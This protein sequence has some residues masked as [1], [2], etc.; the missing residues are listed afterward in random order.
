VV[1]AG[2][3]A[4]RVRTIADI[5]SQYGFRQASLVAAATAREPTI[6]ALWRSLRTDPA[7]TPHIGAHQATPGEGI[8]INV[9]QTCQIA[10]PPRRNL[11]PEVSVTITSNRPGVAAQVT[12]GANLNS[13]DGSY[14]GPTTTVGQGQF[15][16]T[17]SEVRTGFVILP[18]GWPVLGVGAEAIWADGS[19][20][21]VTL[22]Y[23]QIACD[24]WVW[25]SWLMP[26][27][28]VL[29]RL[30]SPSTGSISSR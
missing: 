13:P 5:S 30:F 3:S 9:A 28:A 24:P 6:A 15:M 10:L 26:I 2:C 14:Q 25:W 17:V 27:V 12:I 19:P 21:S 22:T 16:A 4:T 18:S 23:V 29:S 8:T 11:I 1:T 7:K 20:H